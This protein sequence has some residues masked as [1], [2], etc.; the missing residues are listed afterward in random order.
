MKR[1]YAQTEVDA[2]AERVWQVLTD[3]SAYTEWN[4]FMTQ[5]RRFKRRQRA[6]ALPLRP[7]RGEPWGLGKSS[8]QGFAHLC[9][10]VES[11]LVNQMKFRSVKDRT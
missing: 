5:V 6:A 8:L 11:P 9:P 10:W 3:V 1:L 2:S 4:P 7:L